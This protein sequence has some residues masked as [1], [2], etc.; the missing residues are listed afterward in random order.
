MAGYDGSI[1]IN[2]L[3]NTKNFERSFKQ[4][5]MSIKS[6]L[7]TL[8]FG[9]SIAGLVKLS[10]QAIDT[11]SDM[12]E[13]QNVVDTAFGSMSYK[14][15][16]FADTAVKQFG[17]SRLAAKQMAS[18][19]MAMGRSM[20]GDINSA[21]D[22]AIALTARAAD[23]A[24]F[25]NKTVEETSTALKSIYTGET[26]VLKAYGVVMTEVNLQEYAAAHGI[27][28]KIS[29]MTQAEKVQLGYNYVMEQ[30]ALA[31]GDFAKTSDSWANQTRILSEQFK[32]LLSILGSGLIAALT[33][34]IKFLN[35]VLSQL[36]EI[37]KQIG[38]ILSKLF[39]ISIPVSDSGQLAEDLSLAAGG[40][41]E[42]AEGIEEAGKAANKAL[43]PF[44][45]LNVLSQ[46]T[47]SKPGG[48]AGGFEMPGFEMGDMESEKVD[49]V[50][51]AL[52]R[53]L[54]RLRE[55]KDIFMSGFWDGLGDWEYR[56]EDIKAS[57]ETI[58]DTLMDIWTDPAVLA[59]QSQ[60]YDS[61]IYML[62]S[63]AGSIASIGLTIAQNLVGGIAKYLEQNK[64]RIKEYIRDMF[65]IGSE[66]N[67]M[68]AD[69][70][71]SIAYI[72]EAFGRESGQQ[73][74]ANII[75][76][77]SNTFMEATK[78]A[79]K[80]SRDV[81]D[82]ITRP[83]IDNKEDFRT[84]LDGFLGVLSEVTG[85]IKD[86]LDETFENL[87]EVYNE[88][89]KPLF[90]SIA[91]GL[92]DTVGKFLEMWNTHIQP[93][94]DR[95]A[96]KFD[97]LWKEH[98]QPMLNNFMEL[99]GS[100]ADLLKWLWEEVLK[101][102]LDWFIT[103][104]SPTIGSICDF[105]FSV[106]DT[107]ITLISDLINGIVQIVKGVI[108][109]LMGL[110][111]GDWQ[112]VWDGFAGVIAG[113]ETVVKGIVNSIIGVVEALANGVVAAINTM[114]RAINSISVDIPD[115]VPSWL[116]GGTTIGFNLPE[117]PNVSIPRLADGAVIRGG[118]PFMA[119][120][121]DQRRGQ[122]NIET[123]LPTMVK[124]FK[125]AIAESGGMGGGEYTFIAQLDGKTI[126]NETIKQ[127]RIFRKS[128]GHS[129]FAY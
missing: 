56:W 38:A 15:E 89:F 116:G 95:W 127:D 35:T 81:I 25:Y 124:A 44:D 103:V 50:N 26:E 54:E 36:I 108:D 87:D 97:V 91:G 117:I 105:I 94:L 14:I 32:E 114:I 10:K 4:L 83:F 99:L 79:G 100:L 42:L 33:P 120:L 122:T 68:I 78:L 55:I 61:L 48:A 70:S 90:D 34:A 71:G 113:V 110:L 53:L 45:R 30:T 49:T 85:T 41:D 80:F 37:A 74:T 27:T 43:A 101:P 65:D 13:V 31:A 72:F 109:V 17:I 51:E 86:G 82:I 66:I 9:L 73:L 121:G 119:V 11:A 60:Y 92:S 23:M 88:H 106:M 129:G 118:D 98:L 18:T 128:H 2:T 16:E 39:G 76:I 24:S 29:A 8:G 52:E 21:S 96:E 84:A 57:A 115:S 125:Q 93:I 62:G 7:G 58:K 111:H 64:D 75:G 22:M 126:F 40:A 3:L 63:V 47:G 102:Q 5:G 123:P 59:S 28:K 6:I 1:R 20:T 107:T 77:L 104:L 112:R 69:F 12:Q 46:D 67:L 19:F